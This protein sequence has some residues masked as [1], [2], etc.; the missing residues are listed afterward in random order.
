MISG[1]CLALV[2]ITLAVLSGRAGAEAARAQHGDHKTRLPNGLTVI[3]R[4]N[5]AVPAIAVSLLIKVGAG[6]ETEEQAGITNLL[7]QVM[8]KGTTSRSALDIARASEDIGGSVSGSADADFSEIRGSALARRWWDL[9]ALIADIA[10][11]PSLP[12]GEIEGERRIVLR[13]I[14]NRQDQPFPLAWDTMMGRLYGGHPYA[15]PALGRAD[16]VARLDREALALHH[17]RF[18]GAE[19]MILSVS[20]DVATGEVVAEAVRLFGA[21]P[22][23]QAGS[24]ARSTS[25]S[26]ALDRVTVTRPSAQAQILMGFIAPGVSHPDYPAVKVLATVL[27]G[28]MAGRLFTEL[29]DKQGLAYST[30][31]SYPTRVGPSYVLVQLGTAPA[32]ALRA[33]AGMIREIERL[34]NE[35]LSGEELDRAKSYLLGQFA[36]DR[37][38]NARLAWYAAFFEAEGVGH[39]FDERY[40]R[41]VGAVTADD[42]QR[43]ARA[44]LSTPT[45][46][47]LGPT[48]P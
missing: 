24:D 32:N 1:R 22:A 3:V 26:A 10:L 18:F 34:R 37:R 19:R 5:P 45:V 6:W 9:L 31:A 33:E 8:I 28:G 27:G 29:R 35:T 46:V 38:T 30:G 17:R 14:R 42:V 23:A 11:R 2:A 36:L 43:V 44:Y 16:S 12:D 39:D 25:A 48:S 47:S 20:G 21:A 41:A 15:R 13:A 7:Q 4:E 40:V